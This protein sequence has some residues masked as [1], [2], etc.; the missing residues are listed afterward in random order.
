MWYNGG[1]SIDL[2]N[3]MPMKALEFKRKN[4]VYSNTQFTE[5]LKDAVRFFHGTPVLPLP[6]AETFK[7]AGVYAIYCVAKKGIYRTFGEKLN[8]MSYDVPIYVGK[9]V[10]AGWHQN[11]VVDEASGAA[12]HMRLKQHAES[13]RSG[14]GL[15]IDDFACRFAI[16]E[17]ET[18]NM[19]AA[20]EAAII[21]EHTPLWNSVIDGF[22]NH[23]PGKR[24][25]TG[26]RPQWDCL[27]PGREWAERMT[28][29]GFSVAELK[30]R[31]TDYLVGLQCRR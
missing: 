11:R 31:V 22:G 10:P 26:K 16:L 6:P 25:T 2:E 28:G 21:A 24:R 27:H 9:A 7:G 3:A 18:A 5:L 14:R 15:S 12:L 19:I 20:L 13:I 4:H 17:G 29:E 30:R 8:R 1:Q 23:D